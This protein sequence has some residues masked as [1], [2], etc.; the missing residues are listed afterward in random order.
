MLAANLGVILARA[1]HR[2][3][4]LDCDPQNTLGTHLGMPPWLRVGI[5]EGS[6]S[7]EIIEYSMHNKD[8]NSIS[9]LYP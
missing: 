7:S 6:S 3:L 8:V 5:A 9:R 4:V 1:G 2:V